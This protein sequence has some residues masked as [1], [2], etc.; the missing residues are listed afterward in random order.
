MHIFKRNSEYIRRHLR[1]DGIR[2]LTDLRLPKLDLKR[3]VLIQNHP[4]G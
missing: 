2:P 4:A 3:P 1:I